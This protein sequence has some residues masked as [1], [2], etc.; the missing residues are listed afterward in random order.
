ML[1]NQPRLTSQMTGV[2][3]IYPLSTSSTWIEKNV[4]VG[5]RKIK[6]QGLTALRLEKTNLASDM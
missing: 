5:G 4:L 3:P 1:M 2:T 6:K